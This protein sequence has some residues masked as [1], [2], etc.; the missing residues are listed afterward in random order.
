MKNKA[1]K[2]VEMWAVVSSRIPKMNSSGLIRLGVVAGDAVH[3]GGQAPETAGRHRLCHMTWEEASG[4]TGFVYVQIH[5]QIQ[6]GFGSED[7]T[8]SS[9]EILDS[10]WLMWLDGILVIKNCDV[11]VRPWAGACTQILYP[12]QGVIH[13]LDDLDLISQR[14]NDEWKWMGLKTGRG[15]WAGVWY[16]WAVLRIWTLWG[17]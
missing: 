16:L 1:R 15:W 5:F 6:F 17:V 7:F 4:Y 9:E 2:K 13:N 8:P 11:T 3:N 10:D 14:S 12:G